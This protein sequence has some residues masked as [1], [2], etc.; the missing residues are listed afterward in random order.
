[1]K[2]LLLGILFCLSASAHNFYLFELHKHKFTKV[3]KLAPERLY[4]HWEP[5]LRRLVFRTTNDKAR[6][7]EEGESLMAGS[8]LD[9]HWIG[10]DPGKRYLLKEDG[11]WVLT[12]E[13]EDHFFWLPGDEPQYSHRRY[14][15]SK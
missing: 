9:G 11:K 10:G 1:M 15:S 3:E 14:S 4:A 6:F 8:V 5:Q 2:W 12:D 13:P 7:L